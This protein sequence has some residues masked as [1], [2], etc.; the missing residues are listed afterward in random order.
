[1]Y[2]SLSDK[3]L[4]M[5]PYPDVIASVKELI[6]QIFEY[7]YFGDNPNERLFRLR[8]IFFIVLLTLIRLGFVRVVISG[9]RRGSF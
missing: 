5:H 7:Q 4:S 3:Y 6:F 2:T 9:G 1:M 8:I